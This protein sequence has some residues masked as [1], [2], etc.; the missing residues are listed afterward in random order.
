MKPGREL[1]ELVANQ[2]MG[3]VKDKDYKI[4]DGLTGDYLCKEWDENH[5][6]RWSPSG[7]M[8]DAW[9][10]VEK[11]LRHLEFCCEDGFRLSTTSNGKWEAL[12]SN[13]VSRAPSIVTATAQAETA[14]HAICLAA[15]KVTQTPSP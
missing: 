11:F 13:T 10:V 6:P 15:L 14:P 1:D 3:W 9:E 7:D 2:V 4:F 12:F 8:G 5:L